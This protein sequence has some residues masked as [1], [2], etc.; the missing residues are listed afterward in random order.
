MNAPPEMPSKN[1]SV[2]PQIEN[3]SRSYRMEKR[4]NILKCDTDK[5]V[6]LRKVLG[7]NLAVCKLLVQRGFEDFDSARNFFRPDL[8]TLHS[9]WLMKDMRKAVDRIN[10]AFQTKEKILIF[11]DYD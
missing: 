1:S 10:L 8:N 7:V 2:T 11:G 4:W 5:V 3:F 9:P 6:N